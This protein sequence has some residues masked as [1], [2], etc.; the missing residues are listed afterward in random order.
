MPVT[1]PSVGTDIQALTHAADVPLQVNVLGAVT[2]DFKGGWWVRAVRQLAA[3]RGVGLQLMAFDLRAASPVLGE[4]TL[5]MPTDGKVP[6]G[7]VEVVAGT[8]S[9][10]R[11]TLPL[12]VVVTIEKPPGGGPPLELAG[13]VPG[14]L[15]CDG[16]ADFP[17]R[18]NVY[19]L[20]K[21]VDLAPPAAP[22]EVV[23]KL[24]QLPLTTSVEQS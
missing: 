12:P 2:L 4:V 15:L 19:Q 18:G 11:H 14:K 9:R 10:Y 23:A 7:T 22:L 8:P 24:M 5:T 16:M 1:L 21:P 6:E 3:G 17:P 20:Q 13:T